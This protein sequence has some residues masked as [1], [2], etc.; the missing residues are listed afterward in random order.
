[1]S[2]LYAYLRHLQAA[3]MSLYQKYRPNNFTTI[4]GQEFVKQTLANACRLDRVHHGYIFFGSHGIGKTTFAR[5]MAKT[6][7]CTDIQADGNPCQKCET[8]AMFD[9]GK[10]IDVIEIDAASNTGVDNIREIIDQ[11]R[12]APTYAKYKVYIIDEVHMLSKGAFNALLKILEEPPEHVIF[13]LA[14]TEVQKIPDTILSRTLRFDLVKFTHKQL[15]D[16]LS[17][18][19]KEE[20]IVAEDKALEIIVRAAKGGMRDAISLFEQ[21]STNGDVTYEAIHA[22]LQMADE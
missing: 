18:I 20:Q 12:F 22:Q 19:A 15:T 1:M 7:N 6:V 21:F 11:A 3:S 16:H 17:W 2:L 4:V 9:T 13:I 5:V 8:C 14:T 10:L